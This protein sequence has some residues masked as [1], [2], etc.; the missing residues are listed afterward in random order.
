M[1]GPEKTRKSGKVKGGI[2]DSVAEPETGADETDDLEAQL[3]A[4][5]N[6]IAESEEIDDLDD[7]L[8][9]TRDDDRESLDMLDSLADEIGSENVR[10][11]RAQFPQ[12]HPSDEIHASDSIERLLDVGLSL[13]VELGRKNMQIK[14]ILTLGPGKIIELDKLAGE[15]VDLLVNGKLFAKGEV[16]VVDENFGVRIT[17]LI[18]SNDRI[19][20]L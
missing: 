13:S 16:V 10:A 14:D 15:P 9:N 1:A 11:G 2:M 7:R 20:M 8:G 5:A 18:N 6:D 4:V 12:L 3:A 19:R 17:E